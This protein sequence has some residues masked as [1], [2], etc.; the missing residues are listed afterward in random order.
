MGLSLGTLTGYTDQEELTLLVKT[1]YEPE[2]VQ[3]IS[4][5]NPVMK[6]VK[7]AKALPIMSSTIYAQDGS[8]CGFTA[9]G[10]TAITQREITVKN[11][12]FQDSFCPK[13]LEPYFTQKGLSPGNPEDLGVFQSQIGEHI[14]GLIKEWVEIRIWQGNDSNTGEWDG[15]LTIFAA[16]GFGGS[17]LVE[18]N[19]ASAGSWTQ[20][21]TLDASNIDEALLKIQ[22]QMPTAVLALSQ[23]GSDVVCFC[24]NDTYTLA[25]QNLISRNL[26][27][28]LPP[29]NGSAFKYP[30]TTFVLTPVPGLNGTNKLVCGRKGN[31]F[32]GTD[33]LNEE[34]SFEIW[35]SQD[36]RNVKYNVD[37]KYG[38]Q[39]AF[40]NEIVYFKL[41]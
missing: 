27:H 19:P 26:F 2:S 38:V 18:G 17:N 7:S 24:G 33:L 13:D 20:L 36:D 16:A 5:G 9:S 29:D 10:S 21:T 30:G 22:T 6:G 1:I 35:W 23:R 41:P 14:S 28:Y 31:F 4:S 15:F 32:I 3:V 39:V 37:F 12:K 40:L 34:E 25:I 8:S 11:P